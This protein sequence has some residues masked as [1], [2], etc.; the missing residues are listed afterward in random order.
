MIST[1]NTEVIDEESKSYY[2]DFVSITSGIWLIMELT[3]MFFNEKRRALHDFLAGSVV[4]DLI[5]LQ[6]EDLHRR[7][8]ELRTSL[9]H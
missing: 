6:R 3:T 5:E 1:S 2:N 8:Q 9:Q 7:Q 4:I